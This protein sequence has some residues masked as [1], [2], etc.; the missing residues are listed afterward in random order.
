MRWILRISGGYGAVTGKC[1]FDR[2]QPHRQTEIVMDDR[3]RRRLDRQLRILALSIPALAPLIRVIQGRPAMLIRLPVA[4]LLLIGGLLGFLPIL[5]FW[6]LP[7]GLLIL[8]IDLPALRPVV[9]AAI[10]RIRR[11]W[12]TRRRKRPTTRRDDP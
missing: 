1:C 3:Y 5:G 4:F 2:C 6:M 12:Q 9:T 11:W 8:A 7:L 10:I